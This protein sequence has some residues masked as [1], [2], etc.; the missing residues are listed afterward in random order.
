MWRKI[1]LL[2]LVIANIQCAYEPELMVTA[3]PQFLNRLIAS[4]NET[5]IE[6]INNYSIPNPPTV[7]EKVDGVKVTITLKDI[8]QAV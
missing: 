6:T 4:Y 1:L 8:N 3:Q 7:E 2:V 5:I